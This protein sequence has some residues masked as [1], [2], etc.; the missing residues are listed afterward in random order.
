M[1]QDPVVPSTA[2]MIDYWLG[3]R[4][5]FPVDVTAAQAFEGAYG[6]CAAIFRSLRDFSGRAVAHLVDHG[7]DNFLVFGAGVPSQGNVHEV[8]SGSH[9][10]YTDIDPVTIALGQE[11]L[12]DHQRAGYAFGDATDL[13]SIE[14]EALTRFLPGWG[15]EPIGVVF[16]GLAAFLDDPTLARTL[17]RLHRAVPPGSMLA[18]DFD[19]EELADHPVALA[20]MG[21]GFHMRAPAGFPDLLGDWRLTP[22]GIVPVARWRA[23]DPP[24]D[25]PDAFH[26]G[27]A[28]H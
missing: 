28:L 11:I 22:D 3:G 26:G 7:I 15:R 12:A 1:T 13:S 14:P 21:D 20:M 6:P 27:V 16:L 19:G 2:R 4:H 24:A 9:V 25:V 8:A 17:A 5:H 10:L 18:F 23:E